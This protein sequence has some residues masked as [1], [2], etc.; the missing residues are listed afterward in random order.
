MEQLIRPH[1]E[2][3]NLRKAQ[4]AIQTYLNGLSSPSSQQHAEA[5][6]WYCQAND[7]HSAAKLYQRACEQNPAHS[8]LH[9]NLASTLRIQGDVAGAKAA[10]ETH[11]KKSPN[12][13]EA[14]WLLVHLEKQETNTRRDNALKSLTDVNNPPKQRVHAWYA[15]GKVYE[16]AGEDIACFNAYEAGADLR[17]N[18]LKYS[19][20]QDEAIMQAIAAAFT[21]EWQQESQA[22]EAA[23]GEGLIFIVGM[24]RSG[25]TLIENLLGAHDGVAMGGELNAFSASMMTEVSSRGQPASVLEAI[26]LATKGNVDAIGKGYVEAVRDYRENQAIVTDKLPLNYLYLGLIRKALPKAR[27]VHVQ[28]H[29]MDTIWSVYKHLFSHAYP[30]SYNLDEITSYYI[31][32][33]SLMDHWQSLPGIDML[34]VS[35]EKLV[36]NPE[37]EVRRIT[38]YCHISYSADCLNFYQRRTQVATGSAVQVRQPVNTNSVGQWQRYASQLARIRAR[39]TDAGLLKN[40]D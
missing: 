29:P 4:Q 30:F 17:R 20:K 12:D 19:V 21:P 1:L 27:I 34:N 32:Y 37:T 40:S 9:Y 8:T 2:A 35:Y 5:A 28:R 31:A 11:L 39:L 24:P 25:T 3:G 15:L 22:V 13:A 26:R 36:Q 6:Y 38:K 18:Y 14:W 10:L 33:R 7:F 23:Q 16:D